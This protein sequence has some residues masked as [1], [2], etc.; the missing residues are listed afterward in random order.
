[1][2]QLEF[3]EYMKDGLPKGFVPYTIYSMIVDEVEVGRIILRE[4]N[5][6]ECYYDGHIGYTVDEKY[7]GHYYSY[8]GCLLLKEKIN[9]DHV[10]ITCDPKNIASKKVIQKLGCQYIETKKIPQ[11]LKKFFAKDEYE[12]EIYK[13]NLK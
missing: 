13:W 4:G 11:T 6:E 10:L 3:V 2:M 7:R 9:K 5:D 12:K 1:M 8:K